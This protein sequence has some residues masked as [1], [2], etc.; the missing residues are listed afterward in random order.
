[1]PMHPLIEKYGTNPDGSMMRFDEL[2][3]TIDET[4]KVV[5]KGKIPQKIQKNLLEMVGYRIPTEDKYSMVPLRVK[6][7]LPKA[8]GQ[9]L[10]MPKEITLLTGSDFDIDKI[11]VMMKSFK[12]NDIS[13]A[14]VVEG[15]KKEHPSTKLSTEEIEK[16]IKG[17]RNGTL[18]TN[19]REMRG[20]VKWYKQYVISNM[21]ELYEDMESENAREARE[22]RNNRIIDLQWAVL[23][24]KDTVK[25]MVNPGNFNIQKKTGRIIKVLRAQQRG[26]IE[27]DYTFEE[28]SQ[29]FDEKGADAL[30]GL[31][32]FQDEHSVT[33]PS[34]KIYFQQQNMQ[35]A[36]MVGIFAN[37]NVS[38]AFVSFQK[39]GIDLGDKAF[40]FGGRLLGSSN[41][42]MQ[43][44]KLEGFDGKL[45][46]KTIAEFLAASVDTAKDPTLRDMNVNTFTGTVLKN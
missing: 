23:T 5:K 4:G 17:M 28:L 2:F 30:D 19:L 11:Y 46:S 24:H 1:M 33:L 16:M 8:A 36:Q 29:M 13:D 25:K 39:I 22:A 7:F 12:V 21:L 32:E 41:S 9:T 6:G 43:L 31:L 18:N 37:H 35:G 14:D 45:I 15:Y 40:Y 44:D 38:H 20:F 10:M 27:T 34:S 26:E 3:D 42:I